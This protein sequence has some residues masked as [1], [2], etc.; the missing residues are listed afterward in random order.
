M[1]MRNS[2][3]TCVLNPGGDDSEYAHDITG[4]DDAWYQSE[5]SVCEECEFD[6]E[7]AMD[8]IEESERDPDV[9]DWFQARHD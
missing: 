5:D 7:A 6:W 3:T 2:D 8:F 4:I 1:E 9:W